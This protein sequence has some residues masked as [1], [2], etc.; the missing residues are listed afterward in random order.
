MFNWTIG[1]KALEFVSLL[2]ILATFINTN[3][4]YGGATIR[5]ELN[6]SSAKCRKKQSRFCLSEYL[7]IFDEEQFIKRNIGN[8]AKLLQT[9][10]AHLQHLQR[11]CVSRRGWSLGSK[12]KTW[13]F[14]FAQ[15]W[16][17]TPWWQAHTAS[18][19][20]L[21]WWVFGDAWLDFYNDFCK[22]LILKQL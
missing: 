1:N 12:G 4:K 14:F 15:S 7:R 16:G 3:S 17:L 13:L 22:R 19:L 21:L 9:S 11:H 18:W 8:Q 20:Y 6:P 2:W 5:K 10:K